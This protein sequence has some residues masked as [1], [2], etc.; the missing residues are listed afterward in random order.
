MIDLNQYR[1]ASFRGIPFHFEE[2]SRRFGHRIDAKEYPFGSDSLVTDMG[3][4]TVRIEMSIFVLGDDTLQRR[5]DLENAFDQIG[6][7][8]LVHPS[9]GEITVVVESGRDTEKVTELGV[10]DFTV[11]FVVASAS[12]G[13]TAQID[14]QAAV[15]SMATETEV[16]AANS[17]VLDAFD[18]PAVVEAAEV[19]FTEITSAIKNA[20][21][22]LDGITP[23]S[24]LGDISFGEDFTEGLGWAKDAYAAGSQAFSLARRVL[25]I[26]NQWYSL[27]TDPSGALDFLLGTLG[28]GGVSG[29]FSSGLSGLLGFDIGRGSS[30]AG[31]A[32]GTASRTAVVATNRIAIE[33]IFDQSLAITAAK[34]VTV[35]EF[36][37][38]TTA[39]A[40]RDALASHLEVQAIVPRTDL[41]PAARSQRRQTYRALR[42]A[43]IRDIS[44]RAATL[45]V[46]DVY[47]PAAVQPARVLAY[48]LAKGKD[49]SKAIVQRNRV[50]HPSFV[51]PSRPIYFAGGSDNG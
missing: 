19:D 17:L 33:G 50:R 26:G 35:A 22:R 25:S 37:D 29:L 41:S 6:P 51:P 12:V 24:L 44:E 28:L 11:T 20:S 8:I 4:S 21:D 42:I 27:A 16:A 10:A 15:L 5:R 18:D 46:L 47:E 13:P 39:L 2:S 23:S 45:P 34:L 40:T 38:L 36:P 14:T 31:W 49:T 1:Q 43:V 32:G 7:G 3:L 9:R 30:A 48:R